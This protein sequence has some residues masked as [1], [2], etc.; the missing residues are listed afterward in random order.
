GYNTDASAFIGPL[1]NKFGSLREVR[2]AIIGAG[3]GARAGLWALRNEQALVE[4]FVRDLGRARSTASQFNVACHPLAKANFDGFDVVVNATPLGTQGPQQNETPVTGEQLRKVRLAYDL[5][6]NP[7]ETR[8]LREAHA[9]GCETLSGIEMLLAQAA[10]Q[11]KLWTGLEPEVDLMR[12][13][14]VRTLA[15]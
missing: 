1:Q 7:L 15:E 5:V 9:A 8:F 4:L 6:Y 12:A 13:A 2:C 11:F 3:G 10:E 14:A